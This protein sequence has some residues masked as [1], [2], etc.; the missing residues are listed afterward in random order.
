MTVGE[1][2]EGLTIIASHDP[3]GNDASVA[4]AHDQIWAGEYNSHDMP[5]AQAARLEE[6]GWF[7]DHASWSN[8]V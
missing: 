3:D 8:F 7:E 5:A 2:L 4:V 6:L 1:L